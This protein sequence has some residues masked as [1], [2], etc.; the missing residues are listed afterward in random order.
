M[1]RAKDLLAARVLAGKPVPTLL[2]DALPTLP[3][4]QA[5]DLPLA[6]VEPA[7]IAL[8]PGLILALDV[9][10]EEFTARVAVLR[11]GRRQWRHR[12]ARAGRRILPVL[13]DIL[14]ALGQHV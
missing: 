14:A 4:F 7:G 13:A 9:A 6:A 8:Q 10:D 1:G 12:T 11:I 2:R 5:A 3:G